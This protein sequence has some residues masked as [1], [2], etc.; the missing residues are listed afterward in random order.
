MREFDP[1]YVELFRNSAKI[2]IQE[3]GRPDGVRVVE[4][5]A[6]P[7]VVRLIQAHAEAVNGFARARMADMP[8]THAVP[9]RQ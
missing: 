3:V 6:D 7:C 8:R 2:D 1:L 9:F 5:S 4:T